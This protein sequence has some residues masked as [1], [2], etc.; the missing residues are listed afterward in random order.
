MKPTML[1]VS[2]SPTTSVGLKSYLNH[3]FGKYIQIEAFLTENVDT[4]LMEK[5][6]LVLFA[7]KS[8]ST[9]LKSFLT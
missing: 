3:I 9:R 2:N 7:S 1:L 4:A 8:A 5:Y 6:D